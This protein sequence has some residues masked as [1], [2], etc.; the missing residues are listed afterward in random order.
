LTVS[1]FDNLRNHVTSN[2]DGFD[3]IT[4]KPALCVEPLKHV[5]KLSSNGSDEFN[6]KL[7][8]NWLE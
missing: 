6:N 7:T 4:S 5:A 3:V 2:L 8:I 1:N